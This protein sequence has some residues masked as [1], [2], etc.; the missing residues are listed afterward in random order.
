MAMFY[1]SFPRRSSGQND[2]IDKGL[3]VL[4]SI[5]EMGF[6]LTPEVTTWNCLSPDE[7]N[8][9]ASSTRM[10][11]TLLEERELTEHSKV[12]GPFALELKPESLIVL[13]GLPAIYLPDRTQSDDGVSGLGAAYINKLAELD[14]L[15]RKLALLE[16]SVAEERNLGRDLTL[17]DF[18]IQSD[19]TINCTV[20]SAAALL[21]TVTKRIGIPDLFDLCQAQKSFSELVYKTGD[22]K[23]LNVGEIGY[24]QQ[25]EWKICG[26]IT[27]SGE[28]LT[29]ELSEDEQ[30][31]L[32]LIDPT[33]FK[34]TIEFAGAQSTRVQRCKLY[35]KIEDRKA[36][37]FINRIFVPKE[38]IEDTKKILAKHELSI[39]VIASQ[40]A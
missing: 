21:K 39:P 31:R 6:L 12:F 2:E 35:S 16:H 14:L 10:C 19:E 24:Y 18:G 34:N 33:F 32:T 30:Q 15:L 27:C 38:V 36:V 25:R 7:P 17:K 26:Q 11:F 8:S 20:E 37:S 5:L 4:E 29:R 13:G 40:T 9:K 22:V 23:R 1:H 3:T 28:P